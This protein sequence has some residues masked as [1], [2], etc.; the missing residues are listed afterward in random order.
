MSLSITG[1]PNLSPITPAFTGPAVGR[2]GTSVGVPALRTGFACS[3][4]RLPFIAAFIAIHMYSPF[5]PPIPSPEAA[6]FISFRSRYF[7]SIFRPIPAARIALSRRWSYP[8]GGIAPP[9]SIARMCV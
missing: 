4:T 5:W 8:A 1:A 7:R 2:N 6:V 3:L 9:I